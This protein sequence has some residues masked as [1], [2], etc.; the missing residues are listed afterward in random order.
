MEQETYVNVD[1]I[2]GSLVI[3]PKQLEVI[4]ALGIDL[5]KLM[6]SIPRY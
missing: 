4:I 5:N 1:I 6:M 2:E 3:P